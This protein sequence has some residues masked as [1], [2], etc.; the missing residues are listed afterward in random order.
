M[1]T[2]ETM[3]EQCIGSIELWVRPE[4]LKEYKKQWFSTKVR[5]IRVWPDEIDCIAKK[6][7]WLGDEYGASFTLIDDDLSMYVWDNKQEKFVRASLKPKKFIR[8]FE[9]VFPSLFDTYKSVSLPMKLFADQRARALLAERGDLIAENQLGYVFSGYKKKALSG[10][11][12]KV[13]VFTDL[14][15]SL[16]QYRR[17]GSSVVYYGMCWQQSSAKSLANSGVG[18]YRSD[19]VKRDSALKMMKLYPGIITGYKAN[20]E[21]NGGGI[22]IIK[23]VRRVGEVADKHVNETNTNLKSLLKENRLKRVPK[24]FDIEYDMPRQYIEDLIKSNWKEVQK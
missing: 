24:I 18:S 8:E 17:S 21:T 2:L 7:K 12:H 19:L 4:E 22:S 6:R 9:E 10:L 16:Q 3:P 23:K 20:K 14:S 1:K 15:V 5:K 13:F 11:D